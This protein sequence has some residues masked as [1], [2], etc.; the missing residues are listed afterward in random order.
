[1]VSLSPVQ[2]KMAR[3]ALKISTKELARIAGT[4]PM[5][6]N[7]F[8]NGKDSLSSTAAKIAA[9][10]LKTNRIEL[11]GVDAVRVLQE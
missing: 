4:D 5:T 3:A 11:I 7:R 10:L 1:M 2:C 8:E 6:I 9:A